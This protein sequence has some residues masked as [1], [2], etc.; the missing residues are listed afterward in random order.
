[1]DRIYGQEKSR[2]KTSINLSSDSYHFEVLGVR[3]FFTASTD[4]QQNEIIL[5][6]SHSVPFVCS[7]SRSL[8]LGQTHCQQSCEEQSV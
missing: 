5:E 6:F 2:L 7:G 1:L 4:S 8:L 3:I